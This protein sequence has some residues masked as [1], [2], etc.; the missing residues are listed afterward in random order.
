MSKLLVALSLL[1][2]GFT[3][4]ANAAEPTSLYVIK[5]VIINAPAAKVWDK[6]SKFSD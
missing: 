1:A 5:S 4:E 2:F 3:A 6:I